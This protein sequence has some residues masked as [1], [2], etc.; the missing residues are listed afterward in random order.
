M[1]PGLLSP[2]E[3]LGRTMSSEP[4]AMGPMITCAPEFDDSDSSGDAFHE[5]SSRRPARASMSYTEAS[6]QVEEMRERA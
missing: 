3:T 1:N 4:R 2:K 5:K 6:L